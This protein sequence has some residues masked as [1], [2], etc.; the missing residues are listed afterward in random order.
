MVFLVRD[1]VFLSDEYWTA[2]FW[3]LGGEWF[4]V[5]NLSL[6]LLGHL[7]GNNNTVSI[8]S[9]TFESLVKRKISFSVCSREE[10]SG[11]FE[12]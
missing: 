7:S 10:V 9:K 12:V 6:A 2:I 4:Y 1:L 8:A 11:K 3:I 5:E